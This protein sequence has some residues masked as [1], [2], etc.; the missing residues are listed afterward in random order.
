[1]NVDRRQFFTHLG[2]GLASSLCDT[3]EAVRGNFDVAPA[4]VD[5]QPPEAQPMRPWLRPPGALPDDQFRKTCTQCTD[6][7]EACPY[8]SIR[9]LGPEWG[10]DAGM[11][12]IIPTE[13]PCYMCADMPCIK[14]CEPKALLPL[15][16]EEFRMGVARLNRASC[17][18]SQDQRCDYCVVRCPLKGEAIDFGDDGIPNITDDKCTGCGVCS[19]LCPPNAITVVPLG[20]K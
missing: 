1:M 7:Q 15:A 2:R 20:I 19:Y 10:A 16:P 12:A 5:A 18:V 4:H 11:P 13:S 9:R 14:A 3:Y 17:Y 8:Q 6:C